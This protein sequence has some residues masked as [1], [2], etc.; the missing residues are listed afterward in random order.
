MANS[1]T[2]FST[3]S[4]FLAKRGSGTLYG[5]TVSPT[6]GGTVLVADLIDAGTPNLGVPSTV[7]NP[8]VSVTFGSSPLPLDIPLYGRRFSTGLT[9]SISSTQ[10]VTAHFD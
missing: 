5:L 1:V 2:Y 6:A 9:V 8:I 3:S 7:A 10:T 4:T